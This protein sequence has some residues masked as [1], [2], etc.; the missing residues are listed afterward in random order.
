MPR[1]QTIATLAGLGTSV[2]D[3]VLTN[4]DL[5]RMVDTSDEWIVT[6]TGIRER[7]LAAPDEASSD[8]AAAA[9]R[10]ALAAAGLGAGDIDAIL[11]ATVTPDSPLPSTACLVQKT[12]GASRAAAFDIAAACTGFIYGLAVAEGLIA[13]GRH[14]TILVIGVETLSRVTNYQDRNTCVLFGDAAGAAVVRRSA[15]PGRGIRSIYLGADGN[16][17]GILHIP[18]GG[19]RLPASPET[20]AAGLHYVHMNG[21][22]VF[23]FAVEALVGSVKQALRLAGMEMGEID[24]LVPHQANIRIVDA[25]ARLLR[26]PQERVFH[27][28][29]N[30]GNISSASI[31]ISLDEAC[32]QGRLK[33]GDRV[34]LVGFGGG[35]TYGAAVLEWDEAE[36]VTGKATEVDGK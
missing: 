18:A 17:G 9:G 26:V 15:H 21:P 14:D 10:R 36:S 1:P 5:E 20:V 2:P 6:R 35:M 16:G 13:V 33:A 12:L 23:R 4:Q 22:E 8:L 31:P 29:E 32:R 19:S 34:V 27:T 3:R 25:A 11:V 24:L 28:I 7:R 30:Y